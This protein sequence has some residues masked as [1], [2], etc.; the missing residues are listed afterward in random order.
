MQ[1]LKKS[2]IKIKNDKIKFIKFEKKS[3]LQKG[4]QLLLSSFLQKNTTTKNHA[5]TTLKVLV[6][7]I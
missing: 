3:I 7:H 6:A 4:S 5:S 2:L 1:K